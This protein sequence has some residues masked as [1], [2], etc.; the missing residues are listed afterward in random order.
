[1]THGFISGT[2]CLGASLMAQSVKNP[3]AIQET[4]VQCLGQEDPPEKKMATR[5]IFWS[6]KS[7]RQRSLEGSSPWR[8]ES[9]TP[10]SN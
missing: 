1:M 5:S 10:L 3:S 8:C 4:W 7:H 9:Q 6:E 2:M